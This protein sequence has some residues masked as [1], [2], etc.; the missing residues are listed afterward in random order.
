MKATFVSRRAH[1]WALVS[2][3]ILFQAACGAG[4]ATLPNTQTFTASVNPATSTIEVGKSVSLALEL[5]TTVGNT[6]FP[7]DGG[8]TWSSSPTGI[9]SIS[10]GTTNPVTV[11]GL[12]VGQASIS[13]LVQVPQT[14]GSPLQYTASS[15]VN[16]VAALTPPAS[17]RVTPSTLEISIAETGAFACTVQDAQGNPL[18]LSVQWT[19]SAAGVATVNATGT[20]T[21]V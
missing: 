6:V 8:Y 11:S 3:L 21:G 5:R 12:K 20:I 17:V 9:V 19:S 13:V 4:S 16:V 10:A 1:L 7:P 2:V 14:S 15:V 18:S